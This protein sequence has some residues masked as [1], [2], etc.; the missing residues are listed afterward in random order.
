MAR[1]ASLKR[2]LDA[3]AEASALTTN[4][5]EHDPEGATVAFERAQILGLLSQAR[6]DLDD[7]DRAAQRL[8]D[9]TY[10]TCERCGRAIAE[11]RLAALPAAK[12]CINCA[13]SARH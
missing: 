9:G 4:D 7:L 11:Q 8:R 10:G 1:A 3:I 6:G 13:T 2:A 12:T 5:D